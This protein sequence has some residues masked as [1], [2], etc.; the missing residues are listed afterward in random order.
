MLAQNWNQKKAQAESQASKSTRLRKAGEQRIAVSSILVS[1]R[2]W[3]VGRESDGSVFFGT[4]RR[5]KSRRRSLRGRPSDAKIEAIDAGL[6]KEW[7]VEFEGLMTGKVEEVSG[8][9]RAGLRMLLAKGACCAAQVSGA[10]AR[11]VAACCL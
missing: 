11:A 8:R 2:D 5:D 9:S 10:A 3:V 4:F 6:V 7:Q 1:S